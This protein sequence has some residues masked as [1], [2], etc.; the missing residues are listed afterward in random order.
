MRT[1][2]FRDVLWAI[3]YKDGSDPAVDLLKNQAAALV[4]YINAWVR[5]LWDAEDWPEWTVIYRYQPN[6][7]HYIS[8]DALPNDFVPLPRPPEPSAPA[9]KIG[10]PL[11]LYLLDPRTTWAPVDTPFRSNEW[12]IHCGFDHGQN[13]WLKFMPRPPEYTASEWD[14]ANSYHMDDLVYWPVTGEVYRSKVNNN[15]GHEPDDV[16]LANQSP[17]NVEETRPFTP[18]NP[19]SP[20]VNGIW[21]VTGALANPPGEPTVNGIYSVIS[22][23]VTVNPI[24]D[25]PP[26]GSN[27]S[28]KVYDA[29]N[30]LL[31]EGSATATGAAGENLASIWAQLATSLMSQPGLSAF[32]IGT[33]SEQTGTVITLEHP[34]EFTVAASWRAFSDSPPTALAIRHDQTFQPG[35]PSP[36]TDP[37]PAGSIFKIEV[38]DSSNALLG[39]GVVTANGTDSLSII[40]TA[41]HGQLVAESGL[42]GFVITLG[43][44][45]GAFNQIT[46][47]HNSQFT[48]A[49]T[50]TFSSVVYQLLGSQTS[51]YSPAIPPSPSQPQILRLAITE[52]QVLVNA[53]YSLTFI[54]AGDAPPPLPAGLP[55]DT[56]PPPSP[57]SVEHTVTYVVKPTDN[58]LAILSGLVDAMILAQD[59]DSFFIGV[60][61]VLDTVGLSVTFTI[62][63]S[64][65]EISLNATLQPPGTIAWDIIHFPFALM[66]QVVR[67]AY[68]DTLGEQ[69]QTDKASAQEQAVPIEEQVRKS[70]ELAPQYSTL[71][72][73]QQPKSRYAI[74]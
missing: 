7:D 15:L 56:P 26:G 14:V 25:P 65:G 35:D 70:G 58:A 51:A 67:G 74:K 16:L 39:D 13:V 61:S 18:P 24:P 73:Q 22:R 19:G 42:T 6:A 33:H 5:R 49:S 8:W 4:S 47:E 54:T 45:P 48:V 3:A 2:K 36:F 62:D 11:K 64:F 63:L 53:T 68:A 21:D 27:F 17:L 29:S 44:F 66:D 10:K 34:S 43:P 71:S 28:I 40:F 1:V 30:V 59:R 60:T 12:G 57:G 46:F 37:P 55:T 20:E 9:W 38:R 50:W 72:D 41:L 52:Q 32:L 23:D 69:G 31:G